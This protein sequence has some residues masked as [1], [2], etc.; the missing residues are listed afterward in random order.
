MPKMKTNKT[1]SKRLKVTAT[2]KIL[3]RRC[4]SGHL[5]SS[6]S[7]SRIR[8]LRKPATLSRGFTKQARR[9]LGI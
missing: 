3:R 7:P 4:G 1:V 6:K 8:R 2:G 5:K 9:L